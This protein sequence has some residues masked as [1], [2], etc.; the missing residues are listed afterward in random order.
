MALASS[1]KLIAAV[2]SCAVERLPQRRFEASRDEHSGAAASRWQRQYVNSCTALTADAPIA[3]GEAYG[4]K[5]DY[6]DDA[7]NAWGPI[8]VMSDACWDSLAR[9]QHRWAIGE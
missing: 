6:R 9:M 4:A 2:S 5:T 3:K 7:D 8:R 1:R